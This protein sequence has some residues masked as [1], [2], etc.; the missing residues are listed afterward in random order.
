MTSPRETRRQFLNRLALA[1]AGGLMLGVGSTPARA[2]T[3]GG[4]F[5]INISCRVVS[6]SPVS[7]IP[8]PTSPASPS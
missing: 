7:S 5:L 8:K 1:G 4:G 6:T 3:Y 2:V